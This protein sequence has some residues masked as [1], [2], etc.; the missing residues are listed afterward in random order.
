MAK[1]K[2]LKTNKTESTG[3]KSFTFAVTPKKVK[4][5]GFTWKAGEG[6]ARLEAMREELYK[7][8]EAVEKTLAGLK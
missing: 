3:P 4:I 5:P 7:L 2:V 6:K 8:T 1:G